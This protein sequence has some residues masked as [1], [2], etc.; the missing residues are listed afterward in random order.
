MGMVAILV[1][2]HGPFEQPFVPPSQGG[3]TWNL[4]STGLV[5]SEEK[6]FENADV[7]QKAYLFYKLTSEP[8]AQVS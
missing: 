3:S 4:A 1:M 7:Q 2:W 6:I 5:A 8:L